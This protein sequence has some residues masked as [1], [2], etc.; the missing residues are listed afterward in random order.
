MLIKSG[1][2][3]AFGYSRSGFLSAYDSI[4]K[5]LERYRTL[6]K[7]IDAKK[8]K[9]RKAVSKKETQTCVDYIQHNSEELAK[10]QKQL[11]H[12][13]F[14]ASMD[15]IQDRLE[16]E[17]EALSAFVTVHPLDEYDVF[18]DGGSNVES[19]DCAADVILVGL[20][21]N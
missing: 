8:E 11:Y 4:S 5:K 10:I 7:R 12:M 3:D 14:P 19:V 15:S 16:M 9:L 17:K 6:E 21:K 13:Q 18:T 20:V 1:A 2:F